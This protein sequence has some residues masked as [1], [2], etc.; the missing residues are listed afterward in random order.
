MGISAHH[1]T[2][3]G[4]TKNRCSIQ[5]GPSFS[6]LSTALD[7]DDFPGTQNFRIEAVVC[8]KKNTVNGLLKKDFFVPLRRIEYVLLDF[9]HLKTPTQMTGGT[10]VG[11]LLVVRT[12]MFSAA[13]P[14][15]YLWPARRVTA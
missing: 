6:K 14:G 7:A 8:P 4:R 2:S 5:S 15:A 12:G 3:P 9:S 1:R 11:R 13:A 10:A